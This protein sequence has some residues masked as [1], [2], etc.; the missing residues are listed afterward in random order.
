MRTD[1]RE[2][3]DTMEEGWRR[4]PGN[5]YGASIKT[6]KLSGEITGCC[7]LVHAYLGSEGKIITHVFSNRFSEWAE[8]KFPL[9][10]K[11][12]IVNPHGEDCKPFYLW[13]AIIELADADNWST[14]RIVSWLRTH[15][16]D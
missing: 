10:F 12:E 15:Q 11:Q 14:P 5:A 16:N 1:V 8:E 3:A 2:L 4:I 9:L 13:Q 7:P 6:D